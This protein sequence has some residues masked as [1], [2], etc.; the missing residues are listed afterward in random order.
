MRKPW[1]Y[2]TVFAVLM[3][4]A[5]S[6]LFLKH[7]DTVHA[8]SIEPRAAPEF[9]QTSAD[10]WLGSA[11]LT[12]ASL[13]GK[14]VLID[15]WTFDCWNCYRSFPWLNGLEA[16]LENTDFQVIGIHTPEFSHEKVR[17]NI[18]AKIAEFELKHPSMMDNDFQFWKLMQNRY[19]PTF[20][21]IDKRGL[22]RYVFIGETHANT[23]RAKAIENAI[24][25]LLA[26]PA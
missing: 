10:A 9:T 2:R 11:P 6:M 17:S 12:M 4:G 3:V 16:Q 8:Q 20:Y 15:F 22:I 14:V 1:M 18:E 25:A 7:R 26:E 13:R 23:R 19:W 5:V 21:L 24:A